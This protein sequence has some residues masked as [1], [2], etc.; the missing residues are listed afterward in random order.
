MAGKYVNEDTVES[1]RPLKVCAEAG[2]KCVRNIHQYPV[3]SAE[4][5]ALVDSLKQLSRLVQLEGRMP[6]NPKV[7]ETAGRDQESEGTLWD[8][9]SHEN[10]IRILVEEAK[11]NLCLRMMNDYKLWHYDEAQRRMSIDEAM[12]AF[13]YSDAQ[14]DQRCGSF[15]ECLG[16]LLK[17]AFQHVETLQLMDIPLLIEHCV[18]ILTHCKHAV[19]E[20]MGDA[21]FQETIVLYY[22]ASLVKHAEALNNAELLAKTRELRLIDL[23]VTHYLRYYDQC[24]LEMKIALAE[25]LAAL[26]DNEDFQTNWRDFFCDESGAES[27]EAKNYF[28]SLEEHLSNAVLQEKPE[29]K[30]EIRPLLDFYNEIKRSMR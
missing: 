4:W 11:V 8:Q 3:L 6:A 13:E 17:K 28:L 15:E 2:R 30:R 23:A 24:S 9:E 20:T 16:G 21:R 1:E 10:A 26:A 18:L 5:L 14:L 27:L 19:T 22:F 25:G 7:L 12:K 29:K